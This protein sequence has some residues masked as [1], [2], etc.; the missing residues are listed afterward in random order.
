MVIA[1]TSTICWI[2]TVVH[3]NEIILFFTTLPELRIE[4]FRLFL[5]LFFLTGVLFLAQNFK[6]VTINRHFKIGPNVTINRVFM[7]LKLHNLQ[8][9]RKLSESDQNFKV[10]RT[11]KLIRQVNSIFQNPKLAKIRKPMTG[12]RLRELYSRL[13]VYNFFFRKISC[14]RLSFKRVDK[15]AVKRI[16]NALWRAKARNGK[17]IRVRIA[18][19]KRNASWTYLPDCEEQKNNIAE[20]FF[21]LI[22]C[23]FLKI[24]VIKP[25][26]FWY[27]TSTVSMS[28]LFSK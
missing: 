14:V 2:R 3:S 12:T 8:N 4:M 22:I 15:E 25:Q 21:L 10:T 5:G 28:L 6:I 18:V 19:V 11:I 7:N 20:L 24:D 17:N 13:S 23:S 26:A 27:I 9:I 16:R 1:C